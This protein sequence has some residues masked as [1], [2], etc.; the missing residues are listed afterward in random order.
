MACSQ[1]KVCE[2]DEP[3]R[4]SNDRVVCGAKTRA[5]VPCRAKSEPGR[6]RCRFHGGLSTGPTPA[7]RVR[8]SKFQKNRWRKFRERRAADAELSASFPTSTPAMSADLTLE[9]SKTRLAILPGVGS[10]SRGGK[11]KMA[12]NP[13]QARFLSPRCRAM[14]KRSGLPCKAPAVRGWQVCRMHGAR[15]GAPQGERNG[16]YRHGAS[17][18]ALRA[19]IKASKDVLDAAAAFLGR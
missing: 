7:G 3:K 1:Q 17:T 16:N 2:L 6:R 10:V 14:S 8:I 5:G 9:I 4:G 13:M 12:D 15:G 19:D 18:W 11:M